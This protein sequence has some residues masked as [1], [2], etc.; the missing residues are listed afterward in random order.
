MDLGGVGWIGTGCSAPLPAFA[1]GTAIDE[2]FLVACFVAFEVLLSGLAAQ[3]GLRVVVVLE[4]AAVCA[5]VITVL[6]AIIIAEFPVFV[7]VRRFLACRFLFTGLFLL[8]LFLFAGFLGAP[9]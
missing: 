9:A 3:V 2:T 1:V 7:D 4:C 5:I 6:V 8:S